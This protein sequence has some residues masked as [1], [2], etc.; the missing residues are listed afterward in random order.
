MIN[1]ELF[2]KLY[3][4][5]SICSRKYKTKKDFFYFSTIDT[6]D[7]I[8]YPRLYSAISSSK[9]NDTLKLRLKPSTLRLI[10]LCP[11]W[12]LE[13]IDS[14]A[15]YIKLKL[16]YSKFIP[17]SS[18]PETP[19]ELV[20]DL[21]RFCYTGDYRRYDP[22]LKMDS[23][24]K[25]VS[26]S[27]FIGRKKDLEKLYN[28]ISQYKHALIS[29]PVGIGKTY[30]IS[31]FAY[32]YK[33]SQNFCNISYIKYA[34]TLSDTLKQ[35]RFSILNISQKQKEED[36]LKLINPDSLLIIDDVNDTEEQLCAFLESLKN[37]ALNIIII[38]RTP[39]VF[40][41]INTISLRPLSQT[42]LLKIIDF[43]SSN[44]NDIQKLIHTFIKLTNYNTFCCA[45]LSKALK[46][47][48]LKRN[49]IYS[50]FL[51][52]IIYF[53]QTTEV[54]TKFNFL[55]YRLLYDHKELNYWGHIKTIEK[56][57]TIADKDRKVLHF[58]SFFGTVSLPIK[59]LANTFHLTTT[60][61]QEMS[62]YSIFIKKADD[63]IYLNPLISDSLF[64]SIPKTGIYT[65]FEGYISKLNI[66]LEKNIPDR[67]IA[68]ALVKF[69]QH[70][71][72]FIRPINNAGQQSLT[73]QQKG[74]CN[75]IFNAL[76]FLTN[77]NYSEDALSIL[78]TFTVSDSKLL[79]KNT[80]L[81]TTLFS[82]Y[83][84]LLES[85]LDNF[86]L[87]Y[88]KLEKL[89]Q[90]DTDFNHQVFI[91]SL[92]TLF[93]NHILLDI[94]CCENYTYTNELYWRYHALFLIL[95]QQLL[96]PEL[97]YHFKFIDKILYYRQNQIFHLL[98]S[99]K[100]F[101]LRTN[102]ISLKIHGLSIFIT[103][104]F[105]II[106]NLLEQNVPHNILQSANN[107]LAECKHILSAVINSVDRLSVL[108]YSFA[109]PAY[110]NYYILFIQ[111]SEVYSTCESDM[112]CLLSKTPHANKKEFDLLLNIL[113]NRPTT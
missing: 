42:S 15:A 89:I 74:W 71:N 93:L 77:N 80:D 14:T 82:I 38:S 18:V 47:I 41:E 7:Y 46:Y 3:D 1:Y 25:L 2:T 57:L 5:A 8:D 11:Q 69:I 75:L 32:S 24:L 110:S 55:K 94:M 98:K 37:F 106:T 102:W 27:N 31:Y 52:D 16:I 84:S 62:D 76:F 45:S 4:I 44:Q 109:L 65:E 67:N 22:T 72:P 9:H 20:S 96:S 6:R 83:A 29:G 63:N 79:H 92:V 53:Y 86:S 60:W 81:D 99:Y 108:D 56:S 58:L 73:K 36:L 35:L 28:I 17:A 10:Q 19:T 49:D 13:F 48:C 95:E 50:D 59:Y 88:K 66:S 54:R 85:R 26:P 40:K 34:R 107:D 97:Y 51:E 78:K 112:K 100:D 33:Y 101:L 43:G 91:N 12:D 104:Y 68:P 64:L 111:N 103:I 87:Y 39:H 61:I 70:I 23:S 90:N 30:F 105:R 21:I 113:L